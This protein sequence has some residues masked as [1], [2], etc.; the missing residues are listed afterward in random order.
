MD[1]EGAKVTK[2]ALFYALTATF[3]LIAGL[4]IAII[5]LSNLKNQKTDTPSDNP[6]PYTSESMNIYET[7]TNEILERTD[8]AEDINETIAMYRVYIENTTDGGAKALLS[9]DYYMMLMSLDTS[10]SMKDEVISG[11]IDADNIIKDASSALAVSNAAVYYQDYDISTK[12][13]NIAKN[14]MEE[15]K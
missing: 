13:Q 14:R 10:L 3:L 7:A 8:N 9:T 2:K 6:N 4:I 12:Y 11:L 15:A 5:I 1:A